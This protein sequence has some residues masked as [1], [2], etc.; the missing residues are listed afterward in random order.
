MENAGSDVQ[1]VRL[2]KNPGVA[3]GDDPVLEVDHR[4]RNREFDF[5]PIDGVLDLHPQTKRQV[6]VKP[7]QSSNLAVGTV[8]S[9]HELAGAFEL[10]GDD[11]PTTILLQTGDGRPVDQ[12]RAV[13]GSTLRQRIVE[14][15]AP[16]H[17][18]RQRR[19][20]R[21]IHRVNHSLAKLPT[22]PH[23]SGFGFDEK[24]LVQMRKVISD[25]KR[26]APAA[27]LVPRQA[28]LFD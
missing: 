19:L 5:P 1:M 8:G 16:R 4:W 28:V 25:D 3:S 17:P 12:A 15:R 26:H 24:A 20:V 21:W 13:T 11:R 18:Q 27:G 6:G 23:M 9:D 2:R 14:R 22:M 10:A 7:T